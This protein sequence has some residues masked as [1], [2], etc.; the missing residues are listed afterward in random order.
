MHDS[1]QAIEIEDL[2]FSYGRAEALRGVDLSVP[3][4][5]VFGFLG[6]NGAGKSTTIMTL[7]GLLKPS[8]GRVRVGGIDPAVD[9]LGVR[10][11]V[12]FMAED[13]RMFGWMRVAALIDWT[14]RFYPTWD[15]ALSETLLKRF[16]LDPRKRVAALSKGQNS[17][18][19][20][21]LALGHRPRVVILDDPTLGLDPIAR[22]QFLRCVIYLLQSEGATV[23]FSSH[24][25]Y[26]IEPIADHLAILDAGRIVRAGEAEGIRATVRKFL[27]PVGAESEAATEA[28]M[29]IPGLLDVSRRGGTLVLTCERA[30]EARAALA[31]AGQTAEELALNLDE[32]FE[33]YV[34]GNRRPQRD[35]QAEGVIHHV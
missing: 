21:L 2:H 16:E 22:R 29:N 28:W 1:D 26:E 4:G 3:P 12:G 13:Q 25:L 15:R 34:I 10:R 24:L 17:L 30:D 23:F 31:A 7:L 5:S 9:P 6:R 8:A 33:A 19:A 18:L 14:A 32:I 35:R 11:S 27:I 20:L